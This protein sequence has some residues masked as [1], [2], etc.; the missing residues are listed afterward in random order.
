MPNSPRRSAWSSTPPATALAS[1]PTATRC[2]SMT[3]WSRS[4]TLSL[5]QARSRFPAAR[6]CWGSFSSHGHSGAVRQHRTTMCNCTSENLEIPG[7]A[8]ARRPGMTGL[9]LQPRHRDAF[10]RQLIGAL[11][12]LMAGGALDPVPAHLMRLQRRVEA[13]PQLGILDRLLVA[14]A[15]AVL[16]PAMNPPRDALAH[17]LAV[18]GEVDHAGLFQ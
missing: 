18:G 2:W 3:A 6:R 12:L 9:P 17:I 14:G 11:V 4:S 8:L 10:A 7:L 13:L 1:A 16:L 15:P 5:R